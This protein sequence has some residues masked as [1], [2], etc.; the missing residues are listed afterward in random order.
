MTQ[1][2]KVTVECFGYGYPVPNLTLAFPKQ[3]N[4]S[5]DGFKVFNKVGY[6]KLQFYAVKE[7]DGLFTC[8]GIN[9]LG[10]RKDSIKIVGK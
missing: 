10:E 1:G 3:F 8:N 4:T 5:S 6:V 9:T 2:D 7:I